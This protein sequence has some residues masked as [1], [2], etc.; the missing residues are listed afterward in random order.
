[1]SEETQEVE[2]VITYADKLRALASYLDE[3]PELRDRMGDD[4]DYPSFSFYAND[5][6]D[7]QGLCKHLGGFEKSGAYGNLTALHNQ[8]MPKGYG[9]MYRVYLYCSGVCEKVIKTDEKGQPVYA[10]KTTTNIVETDEM[11]PVYEW[12]CPDTWLG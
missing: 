3:R 1:M 6:D 10:R 9:R 12:K 11:E 4:F 8:N 7:F 5:F 2:E